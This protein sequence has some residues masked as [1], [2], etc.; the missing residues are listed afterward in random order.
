M[1]YLLKYIWNKIDALIPSYICE[2]D[3]RQLDIKVYSRQHYLDLK[4]E[5]LNQIIKE[6]SFDEKI[7]AIFSDLK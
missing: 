1:L 5:K 6:Q 3:I 4:E 2:L 7:E